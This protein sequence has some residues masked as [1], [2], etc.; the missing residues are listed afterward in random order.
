MFDHKLTMLG[1]SNVLLTASTLSIQTIIHSYGVVLD[2]GL[3]VV[4][5]VTSHDSSKQILLLSEELWNRGYL[6]IQL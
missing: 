5:I 3:A 2:I 4:T 6:R 1:S